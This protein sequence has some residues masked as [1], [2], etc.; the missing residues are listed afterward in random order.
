M[1]F[2]E[3]HEVQRFEKSADPATSSL[4]IVDASTVSVADARD[5]MEEPGHHV[6]VC[7]AVEGDWD[8]VG[9]TVIEQPGDFEM[10]RQGISAGVRT[11]R[12]QAARKSRP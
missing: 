1:T 7:G 2:Q 4:W 10:I 6:V 8:D 11:L 5:F 12:E 3:M 9:A